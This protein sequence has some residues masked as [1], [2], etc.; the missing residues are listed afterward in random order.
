[1]GRTKTVAML[2]AVLA[3]SFG[4]GGCE[5]PARREAPA[6]PAGHAERA[7]AGPDASADTSPDRQVA[8]T[9]EGRRDPPAPEAST[10]WLDT[11]TGAEIDESAVSQTIYVD[12]TKGDDSATGGSRGKPL[13]TLSIAVEVAAKFLRNGEGV[14]ILLAPGTYREE[15]TIRPPEAGEAPLVIDGATK[16]QVILSGSDDWSDPQR[17]QPVEGRPGI[18]AA[19]WPHEWGDA[20]AEVSGPPDADSP[21]PAVA[22]R[23]EMVFAD[24]D[25]L[26]Q[27]LSLDALEPGTFY[28]DEGSP[29]TDGDGCLYLALPLDAERGRSRIEVAVRSADRHDAGLLE[30]RR[31]ASVVLR[32]LVV[33]HHAGTFRNDAASVHVSDCRHVLVE[34][35]T[36]RWNNAAG[37]RL[38]N[39]RG[40]TL[41]RCTAEHNG[42]CGTAWRLCSNL[43]AEDLTVA[44]N[45]WRGDWGGLTG[46]RVA[47]LK[48]WEAVGDCILRGVEARGNA[49]PGVWLDQV[50]ARVLVEDLRA[51]ENRHA[52]LAVTAGRGPTVLRGAVLARNEGTGLLLAQ[53]QSGSLEGSTLYGNAAS[54]IEVLA[55]ASDA[56]P[57][58]ALGRTVSGSVTDWTWRENAVVSTDADAPLVRAPAEAA[59]LRSL[60]SDRNLWFGPDEDRTFH[61]AGMDLCLEAWQ[62]VTGQDRGSRF[63]EPGFENAEALDFR[64]RGDSPLRQR[65]A[66]PT[67][68]AMPGGLARLAEF[69]AL[70]ARATTA[71]PYPALAD[72]KDATWHAV[73]LAAVATRPLTREDAWL[74]DAFPELVPGPRTIHGVPFEIPA[75]QAGGG[76][77]AVVLRS[78][79]AQTAGGQPLPVAVSVP[80]GRRA[81]TVYVLHGCAGRVRFAPIGRYDLV[82][83]DGTTAGIDVVPLGEAADDEARLARRR[84]LA[85]IQDWRPAFPHFATDG[86]RQAMIVDPDD[87][88]GRIRYLYTLRWPNPHPGKTIRAIRLASADPDQEVTLGV[89]AVTLRLP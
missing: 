63:I 16:G 17:W 70:L 56:G 66:W 71:P 50:Q 79:R 10:A 81:Q 85:T 11:V 87:P 69:R 80:V 25:L 76:A 35:C 72:A 14:R 28:V 26:R 24:G 37:L 2:L 31:G 45:N 48:T 89:V 6:P 55:P 78:A 32:N 36:F 53:A 43:L 68:A 59:F 42:A 58:P 47:G 33:Q 52:G 86:A 8:G 18:L 74:G 9:S 22:L 13:R 62:Q 49:C 4:A 67:Q 29:G 21:S 88:A 38:D 19:P 73:D 23:R 12:A 41:R 44:H 40:V 64:P 84:R 46:G 83:E 7:D 51:V 60:H 15:V 5:E 3:V 39:L 65:D 20:A 30:V 54:Q 77:A 1:M 82:Y 34:D 27:V 75:A 61:L 57:H